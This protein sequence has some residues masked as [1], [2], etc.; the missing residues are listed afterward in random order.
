M[1]LPA[2]Q[3]LDLNFACPCSSARNAPDLLAQVCNAS[4]QGFESGLPI[5]IGSAGKC[6]YAGFQRI[7][8]AYEANLELVEAALEFAD[9]IFHDAQ[10]I[11]E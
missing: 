8:L 7:E 3:G 9:P 2:T 6:L 4:G 10:G 5:G 11:A 1:P